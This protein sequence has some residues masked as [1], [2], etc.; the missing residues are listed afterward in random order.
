MTLTLTDIIHLKQVS[1]LVEH[2]GDMAD[3]LTPAQQAKVASIE[4]LLVEVGEP[5]V[6]EEL[7]ATIAALT[8]IRG[9]P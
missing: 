7:D 9:R 2:Q 5:T 3:L 4:S 1:T 8:E 6:D